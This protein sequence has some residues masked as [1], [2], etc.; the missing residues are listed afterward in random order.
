MNDF[1]TDLAWS[2]D[3]EDEP[4]IEAVCRAAFPT[5]VSFA[6]S[7]GNTEAQRLGID[8]WICLANGRTLTVDFKI[9]RKAWPDIL[10]EYESSPGRPGWIRRD[11]PIDFLI[12]AF[13]PS[14]TGYVF[15]W[16]QLRRAWET[17]GRAWWRAGKAE[18][19]GF[20][21]APAPNRNYVTMSVCVPIP[22]L[23]NA[24]RDASVIRL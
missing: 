19:D 23:L 16:L 10:L 11:L 12:V 20:R 6:K 14:K 5:M 8:R 4:F 9:R 3:A 24:I 13:V 15:P 22:V 7:P 1:A 2:T 17:H 21:L 18:V